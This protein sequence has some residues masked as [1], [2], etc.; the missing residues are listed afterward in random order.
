MGFY[1]GFL[2]VVGFE[3]FG[4]LCTFLGLCC[5]VYGLLGGVEVFWFGGLGFL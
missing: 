5:L 3:C 2:S 1:G 4:F